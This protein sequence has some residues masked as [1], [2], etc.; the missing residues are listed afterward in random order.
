MASISEDIAQYLSAI[1]KAIYGEEVRESIHHAIY[2][3]AEGCDHAIDVAEL[4][5]DSAAASA[6][7]AAGSASD[8]AESASDIDQVY[9]D[10]Q[11]YVTGKQSEISNDIDLFHLFV[12]GS[13][14]DMNNTINDMHTFVN[15]KELDLITTI[16][17]F[18]EYV[19]ESQ[20]SVDRSVQE[21]AQNVEDS[22]YWADV[23]RQ[24][25]IK[26]LVSTV[27][28]L[29]RDNWELIEGNVNLVYRQT[30]RV[31]GMTDDRTGMVGIANTAS[32]AQRYALTD[33]NLVLSGQSDD[34]LTFLA[35]DIPATDIPMVCI[36]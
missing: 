7:A 26:P 18:H 2:R 29:F 4:S 21:G 14:T 22:A 30:A 34:T 32:E 3:I 31:L 8:A 19:N 15:E 20:E 13:R 35:D 33:V 11:T 27:F 24:A 1:L 17:G 28:T 5:A 10:M 9:D 12:E 36:W 23:A 25:G 16:A 6:R